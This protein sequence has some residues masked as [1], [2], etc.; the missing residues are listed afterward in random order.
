MQNKKIYINESLLLLC[1]KGYYQE[2]KKDYDPSFLQMKYRAGIKQLFQLIDKAE[3]LKEP[4][5]IILY[6]DDMKKLWKEFKS[7][8]KVR[9]AAGAVVFN[10]DDEILAIFRLQKWD[11]PKGKLE[12]G[13]NRKVAA[14][15]ELLE[16]TGISKAEN[17]LPLIKTYH[18]YKLK[19][20]RNLKDTKWYQFT[21]SENEFMPQTEEN[22][23]EVKWKKK[24]DFL[25]GKLET[26]QNILEVIKA[27]K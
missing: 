8:Y 27:V 15:R 2:N 19:G 1:S 14:Y 24:G 6:A 25:S 4:E 22:I 16:E 3:K 26:Y 9:K 12:K 17:Q 5:T 21:S 18:T 10:P 7:L 11:L 13:E 23:I 20:V